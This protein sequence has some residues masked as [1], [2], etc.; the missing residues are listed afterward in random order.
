MRDYSVSHFQRT[1]ETRVTSQ[2]PNEVPV[3]DLPK[4]LNPRGYE[5]MVHKH[6]YLTLKPLLVYLTIG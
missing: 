3:P 6:G 4:Q 1:V 5:E 2:I